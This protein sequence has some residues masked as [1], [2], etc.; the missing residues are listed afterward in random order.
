ME[1]ECR[2]ARFACSL[3]E[4]DLCVIRTGKKIPGTA[5][6]SKCLVVQKPAYCSL[7]HDSKD[8]GQRLVAAFFF[9]FRLQVYIPA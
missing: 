9:E 1:V 6:P 7:R 2:Q 4:R 3:V 5:Q 8:A